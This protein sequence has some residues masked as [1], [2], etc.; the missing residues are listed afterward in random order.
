MAEEYAAKMATKSLAELLQYVTAR[1]QYREDAVLAALDELARRGQPY[2]EA[3]ALR[4]S[5]EAA[6]R[7]QEVQQAA[8]RQLSEADDSEVVADAATTD[9]AL[10]SPISITILS[11]FFSMLAGGILLCINLFRLGRVRAMLGLI[12]FLVVY[13]LLGTQLLVWGIMQHSINPF[14]AALLF[15]G[16]ALAAYLFWFWPR[17][18]GTASYRNRSLLLPILICFLL[19]WGMQKMMPYLIKQ[20]PQ[21]VQREMEQ[22]MKP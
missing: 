19:V 1:Y 12:L 11:V 18:V 15:N 8:A 7:E 4:P 17:Y 20:Q 13:L 6:V 14:L 22:L 9:T 3:D 2:A 5:L 16:V 10:Y 21:E